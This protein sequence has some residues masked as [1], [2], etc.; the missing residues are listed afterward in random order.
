M[1]HSSHI[2]WKDL[3]LSFLYCLDTNTCSSRGLKDSRLIP[4][5]VLASA[6]EVW[7]APSTCW[8][9]IV[10]EDMLLV[11]RVVMVMR[12]LSMLLLLMVVVMMKVVQD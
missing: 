1:L 6:A 7:A 10:I 8:G 12:M 2:C 3:C 5:H 9:T 4:Q 11:V